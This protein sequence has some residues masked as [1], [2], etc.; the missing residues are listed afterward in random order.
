LGAAAEL[1]LVF[2]WRGKDENKGRSWR[3]KGRLE[4]TDRRRH[5]SKMGKKKKATNSDVLRTVQLKETLA[6]TTSQVSS[7]N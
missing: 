1:V 3:E 5:R 2:S 4:P 7:G 6:R